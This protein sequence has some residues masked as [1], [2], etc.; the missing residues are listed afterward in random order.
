MAKH[1]IWVYSK[2]LGRTMKPRGRN[3]SDLCARA[4]PCAILAGRP[5]TDE[6]QGGER[7]EFGSTEFVIQC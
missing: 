7:G 6:S 1:W 5:T 4:C 3:A 2:P